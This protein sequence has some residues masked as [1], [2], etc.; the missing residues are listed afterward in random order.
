MPEGPEV[1][2]VRRS[3][4]PLLV[5]RTFGRPSVSKKA[6]RTPTSTK[7]LAP[8]AGGRVVALGRHGKLMWIDVGDRGLMVRLGMS[9]RVLV[10]RTA[11]DDVAPHTHVRIPLDDGSELRYVDPRRFGEVSYY[12]SRAALDEERARMGPDALGLDDTTRAIAI[13]RMRSSARTLKDVLLDQTV[14]A[15]VGNIYA[16][17]ALFVARV[18]PFLQ[19]KKL[20][21]TRAMTLVRAVEEVL[22]QAVARRGTS[23]SNYVD[24]LGV[25]GDNIDHVWVFQREGEACRV[26]GTTVSR[27]VQ[28]ARS[29]FFCRRCQR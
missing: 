9:G 8:I 6:L 21:D 24:A 16:A 13:A 5:G 17:E 11:Q 29:T 10:A 19:G 22:A 15:G 12:P 7:K 20:D 27:K 28:G 14:L 25:E 23:F 3:L 2:T 4:E 1:E 26:C 18:S